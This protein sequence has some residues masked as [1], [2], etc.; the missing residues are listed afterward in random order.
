MYI[1]SRMAQV[2]NLSIASVNGIVTLI[3][4][5]IAPLG[6]AAVVINTLLVAIAT[7]ATA[8]VADRIVRYL[9]SGASRVELIDQTRSGK[10]RRRDPDHLDR[11]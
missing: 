3:V 11:S 7:Y 9:G 5:L 1:S 4:L 6:F 10:M 8:T 2:R